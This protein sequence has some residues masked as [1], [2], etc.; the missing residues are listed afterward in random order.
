MLAVDWQLYFYDQTFVIDDVH[1]YTTFILSFSKLMLHQTSTQKKLV[2]KYIRNN[3]LFA[4][5]KGTSSLEVLSEGEKKVVIILPSQTRLYV[6]E[7]NFMLFFSFYV[8]LLTSFIDPVMKSNMKA[9]NTNACVP[10]SWSME[11]R[12]KEKDKKRKKRRG[13]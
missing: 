7:S 11:R 9:M 8:F 10:Q 6:K 12:E 3:H 5:N 2:Y 13:Q 4:I 1:L